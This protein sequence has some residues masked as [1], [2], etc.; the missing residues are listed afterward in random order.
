MN[1]DSK[2]MAE[3]AAKEAAVAAGAGAIDEHSMSA[4]AARQVAVDLPPQ[5]GEVIEG[6][7][8]G[9]SLLK[10]WKNRFRADHGPARATATKAT[11]GLMRVIS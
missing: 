4:R 5:F 7:F 3:A 11:T 2:A 10:F 9:F 6:C 8:Y 1:R